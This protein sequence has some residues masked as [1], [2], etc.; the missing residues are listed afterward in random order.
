[1]GRRTL[2]LVTF[3][4]RSNVGRGLSSVHPD[5][6]VMSCVL[7]NNPSLRLISLPPLSSL[8]PTIPHPQVGSRPVA[9]SVWY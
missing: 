9:V 8:A 2:R 7:S 4:H 6:G 5:A 1:M 3:R